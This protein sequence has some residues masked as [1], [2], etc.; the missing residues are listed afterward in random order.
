MKTSHSGNSVVP[1]DSFNKSP[2][3]A[4]SENDLGTNYFHEYLLH[5]QKSDPDYIQKVLSAMESLHSP[6]RNS[7]H[8]PQPAAAA[9]DALDIEDDLEALEPHPNSHLVLPFLNIFHFSFLSP[10]NIKYDKIQGKFRKSYPKLPMTV[11]KT[12]SKMQF[13]KHIF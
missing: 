9:S 11:I 4:N 7:Y 3:K 5:H 6:H 12:K 10:W 1:N 8:Q 13:R 2:N